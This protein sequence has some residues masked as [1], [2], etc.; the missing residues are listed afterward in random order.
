MRLLLPI[1]IL[2]CLATGSI[3]ASGKWNF[4]GGAGVNAGRQDNPAFV[5]TENP[6]YDPNAPQCDPNSP[7]Y[8]PSANV[9]QELNS[10]TNRRGD[11][12]GAIRLT[13]GVTGEWATTRFDLTYSPFATYYAEQIDLSEVSHNVNSNWRH[14]YTARSSLSLNALANY[15]PEQDVDPNGLSTNRVYVNQTDQ[16]SGGLRAQ[17]SFLASARTTI[18]GNYRYVVRT[19]GADNYVDNSTHNAGVSWQRKITAH[20]FLQTGYEYGRFLYSDGAPLTKEP[21]V[22]R[23]P[24]EI[25]SRDSDAQHHLVTAGYGLEFGRGFRTLVNAGYN[26]INPSDSH[27]EDN[28]GFYFNGEADWTGT[29]LFASVGYVHSLYGGSGS[30]TNSQADNFRGTLRYA[31]TTK[32]SSE[33]S[34]ARNM[35]ER[36]GTG[37]NQE[38]ET[39]SSTWGRTSVSWA[40]AQDWSASATFTQYTQDESGQGQNSAP[41]IRSNRWSAGLAWS[42][43]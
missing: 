3:L 14:D 8:K 31:F 27:L 19:Y 22:P 15:T 33:L 26:I 29:K 7:S 36:L 35:N 13:G 23:D 18:S 2:S 43:Q 41:D 16:V 1:L 32:I 40:F 6:S 10:A 12:T 38:N 11:T 42:F 24:N 28:S 21:G 5:S 20:A 39:V 37:T 34:V 4:S 17:Y 30:F 25:R 9:C